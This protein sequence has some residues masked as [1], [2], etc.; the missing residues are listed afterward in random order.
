MK[1]TKLVIIAAGVLGIIACFL[2]YISE[3]PLSLSMWDFRQMPA[4]NSGLINGPKQ[5]YVALA[6]FAIPA[7]LAA[8]ALASRLQRALAGIAAV[9]FLATFALE[10]VRKGM[11]GEGP[12]GTAI[13]GKLVF[14]AALVGF[15]ASI[16]AVAKPE[17]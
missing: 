10:L 6:A 5:V 12:V 13:G 7:L 2:P 17:E 9:S 1:Q 16:V 4:G 3:G 11:T 15:V 8:T 14:V